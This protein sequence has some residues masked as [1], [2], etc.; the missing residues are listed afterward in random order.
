MRIVAVATALPP[1]V[2][3]QEALIG[4]FE[5]LWSKT[6]ANAR[7]VRQMFEAVQV[8]T[9]HLALP[10]DAYEDLRGFGDANDAFL[11]VGEEVGAE[12]LVAA[13]AKAGIGLHDIDALYAAS[14]TGIGTPSLDARL[15]HRLGLRDDLVRVPLFGLGCAAGAAGIARVADYLRAWPDK[16]AVLLSV[17]LCS[18]TLQREDLSVA[19]LV[20]SGLFGDGAAAVVMAGEA[21]AARLGLSGPEVV[22]W[23][24][25]LY[26]DS[27]RVMGWDI[28]ERGFQVV[29]DKSV[30]EV[31]RRYLGGD[32]R[33]FLAR[34]DL[35]VH[36]VD[37]W[38]CHPGGPA[39]L[40]AFEDAL[41]QPEAA[42]ARTWRSLHEVGNLSSA[43]VLFVLRDTLEDP[44]APPPSG[45]YGVVL[46]MGPGFGSEVVLL[47]WPEAS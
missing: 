32:V 8:Q 21:A 23:T 41:D 28:S 34:H 13:V 25:R 11:R 7:R 43:S 2:A 22:D 26:P 17:E 3:T 37:R 40:R 16:V 31:A 19:N 1:H 39:V 10:I 45:G 30:P 9:R 33:G 24:S 5:R 42:F 4:A 6:H 15:F 47:R 46:A 27:L 20:S 38:V 14:V 18:L 29:L 35:T 12:A 36:D 44:D